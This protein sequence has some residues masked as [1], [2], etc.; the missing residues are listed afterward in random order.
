VT[1]PQ[2]SRELGKVLALS[3]RHILAT[4][5]Y[6]GFVAGI[7]WA[8]YRRPVPDEF[9]RYIYE[10]LVRGKNDPVEMVYPIIKYSNKRAE[11]SSVLDSPTHLGQLEPLY[12]IKP[13][14]VRAIEATSFMRLPIQ[15]R[16]NL[17]SSLSLFGI[18]I[19][20]L[21]WTRSPGYSALLLATS[22]VNVLG[23]MGTPDALST[24]I[25]LAGLWALSQSKLL[26]GILLLLTSLWIRTDN[27][28]PVIA[29][30]GY[31]AWQ[32]RMT[33]VDAGVT[34]A[35]SI[36]S[37]ELMNHFSGNYGWRVLFQYS[38]LGGKSPAEV[39][40]HFGLKEYLG[41]VAHN[42]ETIVPQVTIWALLGIVAWKWSS[43]YRHWLIPV[44]LAVVAHFALFPSAESRY[45]I[46]AFIV[47]GVTFICAISS[48]HEARIQADTVQAIV[49]Y[50][51]ILPRRRL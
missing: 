40:P 17:I 7:A 13:L 35:L 38:F 31:L 30:L 11:E 23:R 44:W 14:Y 39:V 32:K 42:A 21:G 6:L 5:F 16:I 18:G 8:C 9:D 12:A 33:L 49:G 28:L 2:V 1:T 10:A 25:V 37:V 22:P 26:M 41:V 50:G 51:G 34:S 27:L 19:V 15:R 24:L 4:C 45:L 20:L 43:P 46:W 47:T 48:P 36:G 29:V 3:A